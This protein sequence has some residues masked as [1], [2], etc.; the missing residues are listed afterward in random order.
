MIEA[1]TTNIDERLLPPTISAIRDV[2][3]DAD[4]LALI[5]AYGGTTIRI[6]AAANAESSPLVDTI[7]LAQLQRLIDRLG[8]ARYEYIAKCD[9]ALRI[10]RDQEIVRKYLDGVSVNTLALEYKL[11]DRAIE[12]I[13]KRTDMTVT[14]Q[15]SLF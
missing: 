10:L 3:G 4:T 9:K 2:I 14:S 15:G 7:G 13:L 1:V 8:G 12:M 11:S 5:R 6:P